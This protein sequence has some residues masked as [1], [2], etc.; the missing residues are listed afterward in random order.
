MHRTVGSFATS[1]G[2]WQCFPRVTPANIIITNNSNH[3]NDID[4]DNDNG[5]VN[6]VDEIANELSRFAF[7]CD[8]HKF[9]KVARQTLKCQTYDT[10]TR[11]SAAAVRGDDL[12]HSLQFITL[13]CVGCKTH[14]SRHRLPFSTG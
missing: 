1:E 14:A 3:G 13:H 5:D 9:R 6:F 10:F 12:F 4:I 11:H 8:A 7:R 2:T